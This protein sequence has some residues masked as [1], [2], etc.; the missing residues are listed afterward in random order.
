[1]TARGLDKTDVLAALSAERVLDHF[2]IDYQRSGRELRFQVCPECGP[3]SKADTVSVS[4]ATGRWKDH[5][6][7]CRGDLL[8]MV[9]GYA[10]IDLD[11]D[12]G[13]V[14]EVAADIA[15]MAR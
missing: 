3:R 2:G 15:G 7:D 6:H 11:R 5:A 8:S 9:A 12:F 4:T 10:G 14:L 13:R 1:V